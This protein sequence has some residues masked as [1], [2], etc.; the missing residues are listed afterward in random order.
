VA[1]QIRKLG[2]RVERADLGDAY[3]RTDFGK[4]LVTVRPN[5][6]D[7]QAAKTL[8]HELAHIMCDHKTR[9]ATIT[10]DLGEV[11]AESVACIVTAACGLNSLAY[12]V[13]YVAGWADTRD[14][15]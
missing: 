4:R 14:L 12:S 13:P 15:A 6:A 9:T 11:E 10:C 5:L 1:K 7:S 8:T 2:F 3:G